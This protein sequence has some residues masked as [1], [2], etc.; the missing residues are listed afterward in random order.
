[1]FL[2]V[3]N[4][5]AAAVLAEVSEH[6]D[7]SGR[8]PLLKGSPEGMQSGRYRYRAFR[9]YP[10]PPGSRPTTVP[11]RCDVAIQ[12]AVTFR[13]AVYTLPIP[14][15]MYRLHGNVWLPGEIAN[16][17]IPYP[18]MERKEDLPGDGGGVPRRRKRDNVRVRKEG[19]EPSSKLEKPDGSG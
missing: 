4:S 1:M 7:L 2:T 9:F 3:E 12:C 14:E 19:K 8:L 5:P 13:T 17:S 18:E 16:A 15:E 6:W 11:F 10:S